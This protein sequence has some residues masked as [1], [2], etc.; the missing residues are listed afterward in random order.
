[1][2]FGEAR[3]GDFVFFRGGGVGGFAFWLV[4]FGEGHF[5]FGWGLWL[6]LS[7]SRSSGL[8]RL[9][10]FLVG[11][12]IDKDLSPSRSRGGLYLTTI[13]PANFVPLLSYGWELEIILTFGRISGNQE[14]KVS[15]VA[16][17]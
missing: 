4:L 7:D 11:I 10:L 17:I 12:V 3:V 9:K 8:L 16:Q 2:E 14:S 1:M 13:L 15:G 5:G 6:Y